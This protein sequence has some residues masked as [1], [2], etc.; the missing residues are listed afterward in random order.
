MILLFKIEINTIQHVTTNIIIVQK[1][2]FITELIGEKRTIKWEKNT[3]QCF[4]LSSITLVEIF[5]T[6]EQCL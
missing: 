3:G 6:R 5:L 4:L 1:P 2:S